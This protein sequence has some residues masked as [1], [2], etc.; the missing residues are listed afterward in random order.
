MSMTDK[1]LSV[2]EGSSSEARET[3]VIPK[4]AF[5]KLDRARLVLCYTFSASSL[6]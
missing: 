2:G 5:E 3:V 6:L 4:A 1:P